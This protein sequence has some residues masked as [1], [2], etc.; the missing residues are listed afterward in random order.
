MKDTDRL[1]PIGFTKVTRKGQVTIP[2]EIRDVYH[3]SRGDIILVAGAHGTV[4]LRKV[5]L[6]KWNDLFEYGEAFAKRKRLS[7]EQILEAVRDVRGRS[8]DSGIAPD[9]NVLVSAFFFKGNKRRNYYARRLRAEFDS[10]CQ[11]KC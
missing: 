9:T 5:S 10:F 11:M 3:I 8:I 1:R 2:Q 6:P 7:R 4:M